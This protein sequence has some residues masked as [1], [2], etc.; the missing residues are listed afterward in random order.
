MA[1]LEAGR[2]DR[3]LT[4]FSEAIR[5]VERLKLPDPAAWRGGPDVSL[6]AFFAL[7]RRSPELVASA[8]D[9]V[10][11]DYS[12]AVDL[13]PED[14]RVHLSR[15]RFRLRTGELDDAIDDFT[16]AVRLRPDL[17]LGYFD[18]ARARAAGGDLDAALED[19]DETVRWAP[20]DPGPYSFRSQ[21]LVSLGRLDDALHD[22][23]RIVELG[24]ES[25]G[26]LPARRCGPVRGDHL[27]RFTDLDTAQRLAPDWPD[28]CNALAWLL[29][30]LG[31]FA[32]QRHARRGTR[33]P[34]ARP[35][36]TPRRIPRH[37][38]RRLCRS[39]RLSPSHFVRSSS[40]RPRR[41]PR[42][43]TRLQRTSRL[44]RKLRRP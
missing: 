36:R 22:L 15:G 44:L 33:P 3:A 24:P 38:R 7:L 17:P 42:P 1:Y 11:A 26:L 23:N 2:Y 28:V 30:P 13:D 43:P 34:R 18:R 10:L 39:G 16:E 35:S 8:L 25:D 6:A 27:R 9:A 41:R 21:I 4:D 5:R 20:D 14:P 40:D 19:L 37:A 31:R 29:Y 12:R 32:P